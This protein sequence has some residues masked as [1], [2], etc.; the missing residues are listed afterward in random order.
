[1]IAALDDPALEVRMESTRLLARRR[2][3]K[4]VDRLVAALER[5]DP[6]LWLCVW[7]LGE[8]GDPRAFEPLEPLLD[9]QDFHVQ[10]AAVKALRKI[11]N[12]R[13]VDLLYERLEDPN[14][15]DRGKFAH[16]LAGMD[17]MDAIGSLSKTAA[18]GKLDVLTKAL[19]RLRWAQDQ[20]RANAQRLRA[21]DAAPDR[22]EVEQARVELLRQ[23]ESDLRDLSRKPGDA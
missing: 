21:G 23:L 11:D 15:D 2:E 13:A 8:I 20:M 12:A 14:R 16:I 19:E 6:G 1:L 5:P 17:L 22:A 18:G 10:C 3:R 9:S 7:A 4:A